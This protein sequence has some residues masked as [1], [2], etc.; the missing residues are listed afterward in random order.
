VFTALA[1]PAGVTEHRRG[2]LER[3]HLVMTEHFA[4]VQGAGVEWRVRW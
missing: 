1:D 3:A 4:Q 2:A